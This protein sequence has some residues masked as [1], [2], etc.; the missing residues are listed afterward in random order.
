MA[1]RVGRP[2]TGLPRLLHRR[3]S[4]HAGLLVTIGVI[5]GVLSGLVA[6]LLGYLGGSATTSARAAL[7]A[8]SPTASGY[9]FA[10]DAGADPAGRDSAALDI[11]AR[12]LGGIPASVTTLFRSDPVAA[13]AE[14][15]P[16]ADRQGAPVEL[17]VMSGAEL[18]ERASL[19]A[20]RWPA[21]GSV[22]GAVAEGAIQASAAA[23]LGLGV[24]DTIDVST[25]SP[26]GDGEAPLVIRIVGTW[27][28]TD[29]TDPFW[30]SD[31]LALTG[32]GYTTADGTALLG[33][34]VL[35]ARAGSVAPAVD[36][37]GDL[38]W[39]IL[40]DPGRIA[41][42]DLAAAVTA[43][44]AIQ[45]A[46]G[47]ELETSGDRVRVSGD[48]AATAA[49]FAHA[50]NALRGV[51][52]VGLIL[53]VVI[54]VI[55][56][57]QVTRLL[58]AAR[59][60]ESA[61]LLS[62]GATRGLLVGHGVLEGVVVC[63]LGAATGT[64]L[65]GVLPGLLGAEA[66]AFAVAELP[67]AEL[68]VAVAAGVVSTGVIAVT[69][70]VEAFRTAPNGAAVHALASGRAE[71]RGRTVVAL[72]VVAASVAAAALSIGQLLVYGSPIV[73]DSAGRESV[74]PLAVLAP[75]L[76]LGAA[77]LVLLAL[78]VP[79]GRGAER[80]AA[81]IRMLQPAL[82][83]RQLARGLGR[84]AAAILVIALAVGAL[85]V[86]S[87]Y[88]GTRAVLDMTTGQLRVGAD[89][90][91]VLHTGGPTSAGADPLVT[92]PY[93]ALRGVADAAPV[94]ATDAAAGADGAREATNA[95][96]TAIDAARM[97]G[98]LSDV[99]GTVDTAALAGELPA[100]ARLGLPVPDGAR[101]LELHG[102]LRGQAPNT[103]RPVSPDA[104]VTGTLWL[105]SDDG[106]LLAA[107][108]G[109]IV[110][111]SGDEAAL[112]ATATIPEGGSGWRVVA[113][114]VRAQASAYWRVDLEVTGLAVD[115]AALP[116]TGTDWTSQLPLGDSSGMDP[117][118]TFA[119]DAA[120]FT[121]GLTFRYGDR[122]GARA[123]PRSEAAPLAGLTPYGGTVDPLPVAIS[124][125]LAD[126]LFL[127][128]GDP[129][130]LKLKGSVE[131]ID[132]IV[133]DVVQ[134]V[135]GTPARPAILADLHS[136]NEHL[137]RTGE[138]IPA[139]NEL[140]LATT[141]GPVDTTAIA[142]PGARTGT[143]TGT[144]AAIVAPA[145]L[146]L[147]FAAAGSLLF[148][149]LSLGAVVLT[150]AR[151]RRI[152]TM[153]LRAEGLAAA[154]Q[155]RHRFAE[156]CIVVA[157]SIVFGLV[158]G[159]VV[160]LLTVPALARTVVLDA[161][162]DLTA[163]VVPD[164]VPGLALLGVLAVVLVAIAATDALAV[165]RLAADPDALA[166]IERGGTP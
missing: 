43:A 78:A 125:S 102:I 120:S 39:T 158:G 36:L 23:E 71:G 135:P 160:A 140:W 69:S 84:Y 47:D 152:D 11:I 15:V 18:L 4:A 155:A 106:S 130:E 46:L 98:I 149:A 16:L 20:G 51:T 58:V 126:A 68:L 62:R 26:A 119:S 146:S 64:A 45:N 44:G 139:A 79:L 74:D 70:A 118:S 137:L 83:A 29:G 67:V 156:T 116:F 54:G 86:A 115:G 122:A 10:A 109:P 136:L 65:A 32:G 153:V 89:E 35:S 22:A 21:A 103:D 128:P 96:L 117:S 121:M 3:S 107:A 123:M 129:L 60:P 114:D 50:Q 111:E 73:S 91:I 90:R 53:A 13:S 159:V 165:R 31:A 40:P 154:T 87:A 99:Q 131:S 112:E 166:R 42:G 162:A 144:S 148:A 49:L 143:P 95:A 124:Q 37:A 93:L 57:A 34:L 8:A 12:E 164:A 110:I 63:A 38:E 138:F 30:F 72:A 1:D 88:S 14:G 132:A 81:R 56:L 77:A 108:F 104:T 52:P 41:A 48:L 157:L 55:T 134:H 145:E 141:D 101:T 151:T 142:G 161:P 97:P 66:T 147:W 150:V 76:G 127:A 61:L 92:G 59:R 19:V 100:G 80:L 7:A 94:L 105:E 27:A 24:G 133:A 2:A 163:T 9:R 85:V 17:V 113:V 33:P 6:G 25:D 5:V 28:P 82:S 75:A